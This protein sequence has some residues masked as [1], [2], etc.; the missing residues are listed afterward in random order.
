[1]VGGCGELGIVAVLNVILDLV[2]PTK[3]E[4]NLLFSTPNRTLGRRPSLR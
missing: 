2:D 3:I 4:F 1:L